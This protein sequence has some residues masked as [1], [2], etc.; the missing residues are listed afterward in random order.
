[1]QRLFWMILLFA[2]FSV[3]AE[4]QTDHGASWG[5]EPARGALRAAPKA[6][7]H[8]EEKNSYLREVIW[9]AE[10][11]GYRATCNIPFAWANR[12]TLLRIASAPGPYRLWANGKEVAYVQSGA[13]A[14]EFNLTR[15]L[16][17]GANNLE[18][19]LEEQS[20]H[21]RLEDFLHPAEIGPTELI[22]QPTIRLRDLLVETRSGEEGNIVGEIALV[23]KCDALNEKHARLHYELIA[24][25]GSLL[26][27]GSEDIALR[28]R[29]EDTLYL[30]A[31]ISRSE[32]WSPEAP[33]HF[34]LKLSTQS[35]GRH[36]EYHDLMIAF[37][38]IESSSEGLKINGEAVTL[39]PYVAERELTAADIEEIKYGQ[40][41]NL[42]YPMPGFSTEELY[43][44]CDEMGIYCVAQTPLS[45]KNS[46]SS[47]LKGGNPTNDPAYRRAIVERAQR[48]RH[49]ASRH[50]SV[51]AFSLGEESANGI[52]L[53]E[54]YLEGKAVEKIRPII[55]LDAQGEWNSDPWPLQSAD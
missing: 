32:L 43:A 51:I 10:E 6:D 49:I 12:Q 34:R 52:G 27:R 2:L 22:S 44:L 3:G 40:G 4:A 53:Y 50:P 17:E 48:T 19:R 15:H 28:M 45:T 14:V 25:S 42:I 55:Y 54:A 41:C 47:R 33:T 23:V 18:L 26:K 39:K 5:V 7:L 46:G 37:R 13:L 8:P 29:Q 36:T 20:P 9:H 21:L 31:P 38:A 30:V 11:A 1:M 24:P 16:K 35:S